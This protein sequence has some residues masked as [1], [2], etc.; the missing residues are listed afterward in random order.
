MKGTWVRYL[1]VLLARDSQ[2]GSGSRFQG[3]KKL[4]KKPAP[5]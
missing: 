1:A 5:T 3:E 2:E 4:Q